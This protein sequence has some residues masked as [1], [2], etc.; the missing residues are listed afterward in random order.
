MDQIPV[1]KQKMLMLIDFDIC[2][3]C[4]SCVIACSMAKAGV[5][6]PSKSLI[7]L[8]KL[9]GRCLSIP[10]ICEHCRNPPCLHACPTGAVTKNPETG[11]VSINEDACTGC[12]LCSS[13]CPFGPDTIKFHDDKAVLCDLCGGDPHCSRICQQKAIAYM[14]FTTSGWSKKWELADKRKG[15]LQSKEVI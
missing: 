10:I 13:A 7:T 8:R 11:V 3:G 4:Q 12:R 9:E 2:S 15:V 14:P 6:S 5:F 1:I